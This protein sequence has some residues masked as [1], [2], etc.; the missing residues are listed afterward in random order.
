MQ[1]DRNRFEEIFFQNQILDIL[2]NFFPCRIWLKD[3][4][5][6]HQF[7]L[8]LC[9]PVECIFSFNNKRE[10]NKLKREKSAKG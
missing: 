5:Q 6:F 7:P 3:I 8:L 9:L 1:I 2:H 10:R 4:Y